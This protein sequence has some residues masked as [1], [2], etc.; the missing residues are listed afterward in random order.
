MTE[1]NGPFTVMACLTRRGFA[2]DVCTV[3]DE[4]Q[5][6]RIAHQWAADYG[7]AA[8]EPPTGPRRWIERADTVHSNYQPIA[9]A[10]AF[11]SRRG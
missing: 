8:I 7:A 11:N 6:E 9:M 1:S 4:A 5:A 3:Q 2:I 10:L